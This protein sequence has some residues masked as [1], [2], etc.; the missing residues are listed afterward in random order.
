MTESGLATSRIKAATELLMLL[1]FVC[2]CI[3]CWV[4]SKRIL[5]LL[6]LKGKCVDLVEK[7]IYPQYRIA[8]QV[9]MECGLPRFS[10]MLIK[11]NFI[12]ATLPR[13]PPP[14]PP[15]LLSK[16]K[17]TIFTWALIICSDRTKKCLHSLCVLVA[18][19]S[20]SMYAYCGALMR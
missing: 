11:Q 20:S 2:I 3:H 13:P 5:D 16:W 9:K 10:R 7:P 12:T 8:Q 19:L 15:S 18:S 4:L 6:K 17:W 1:L 14:P